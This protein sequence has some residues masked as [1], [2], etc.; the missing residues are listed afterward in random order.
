[1]TNQ[2]KDQNRQNKQ[3]LRR[4]LVEK[5]DALDLEL[6]NKIKAVIASGTD[7]EARLVFGDSM[8]EADKNTG[9]YLDSA[10]TMMKRQMLIRLNEAIR[11][12]DEGTYGFCADCK[13]EISVKR[14]EA[15]PFAVRCRDCEENKENSEAQ[16]K[17]RHQRSPSFGSFDEE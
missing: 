16:T 12:F 14:L 4:M 6:R 5:R 9:D 7:N 17:K 15:L 2:K 3:E 10:V 11:R 8:E 1:M 13:G